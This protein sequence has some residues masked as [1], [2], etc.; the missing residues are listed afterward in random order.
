MVP[1]AHE[2]EFQMA[3]Q[4]VQP[5]LHSSR[6]SVLR[7]TW[8]CPFLK[9]CPFTWCNLDPIFKH[10][11]LSPPKSST[12]TASRSVQPFLR[13]SLPWHTNGPTDHTTRSITIGHIYVCST[14]M[15]PN[16]NCN[17]VY[18]GHHN[19]AIAG[20]HLVHW[21]NADWAPGGCQPSDQA[22]QLGL[23]VHW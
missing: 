19:I 13:G 15:R 10:G 14:A 23:Q 1:W 20:V 9:N 21:L 8:A 4:S 18:S 22:N 16:N 2:S 5:F 12:Q 7:H 17:N 3:S 11:F 6:Q